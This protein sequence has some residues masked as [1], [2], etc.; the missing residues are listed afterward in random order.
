V[1]ATATAPTPA[2]ATAPSLQG[3]PSSTG[4]RRWR[5]QGSTLLNAAIAAAMVVF[6]GLPL[7]QLIYGSFHTGDPFDPGSWTLDNYRRIVENDALFEL[8]STSLLFAGTTTVLC[9][10]LGVGLAWV[11]ERTNVPWPMFWR[12]AAVVP[13]LIPGLVGTTAWSVLLSERTGLVNEFLLHPILGMRFDVFSLAGMIWVQTATLAPLVFLFVGAAL[14]RADPDIEHAARV[15]GASRTR[16]LFTSLGVVRPSILTSALLVF[17]VGLE[18]IEVP[19]IFGFPARVSVFSG[20]IYRALRVETPTRWGEASALSVVLIAVVL[21]LFAAYV[22]AT[23][24]SHR[25]VTVAGR[26]TSD[27]RIDL[28][29]QRWLAFAVCSGITTATLILPLVA[30]LY[31]SVV[32]FVGRPELELLQMA[33]LDHYR[34]LLDNEL[35]ARSVRNS[36]SLSLGAALVAVVAAALIVIMS[37]RHT[38]W[39]SRGNEAASLL[40]MSVPRIAL[41]PAFLWS[42]LFLP[43]GIGTAIYGTLVIM[44]IAYVVMF[45]PIGT[46]QVHS[47]IVQIS[48]EL[49]A[50]SRVS[51]AG[52]L[53]T[54]MRVLAPLMAPALL[55]AFLLAFISFFR[56]FSVS[57]LMY[58]NGTEVFSVAMF[59]MLSNGETGQVAALSVVFIVIVGLA[60]AG[61]GWAFQRLRRRV[62]APGGG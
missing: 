17:I 3:P 14:R 22:L 43:F 28:G 42:Y 25:Y 52:P 45:L 16:A 1:T 26:G 55:A 24:H 32:P 54:A 8:V 18:S 62:G 27:S 5:P 37:T 47:Q 12:L 35:L 48:P 56:E 4:A 57:V 10:V 21:L 15:A 2:D 59:S 9:L 51:G 38:S 11:V 58:R 20:E 60:L 23:R 13:L 44:G 41:A 36:L 49:E 31:A 19:L 50:A 40:P 61:G 29:D 53:S 39:L 30:V 6:V 46:R 7:W 34:G 33:S